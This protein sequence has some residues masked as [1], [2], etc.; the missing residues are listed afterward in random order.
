MSLGSDFRSI[1]QKVICKKMSGKM[2]KIWLNNKIW[3][4]IKWLT[5][6]VYFCGSIA[7][8]V[9]GS[10]LKND[11]STYLLAMGCT[12]CVVSVFATCWMGF[13]TNLCISENFDMVSLDSGSDKACCFQSFGGICFVC[14]RIFIFLP[15]LGLLIW[16]GVVVKGKNQILL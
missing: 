4:I 15:Y 5:L 11:V 12:I 3:L 14:A 13:M 10:D 16:G 8:I 6:V 7:M 1:L 9:V 2:F